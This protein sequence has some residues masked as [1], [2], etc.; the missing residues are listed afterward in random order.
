M[1]A[2]AKRF[3]QEEIVLLE[4]QQHCRKGDDMYLLYK[5]FPRAEENGYTPYCKFNSHLWM[6]Y[7]EAS[8]RSPAPSYRTS[9]QVSMVCDGMVSHKREV[10]D[11]S[12]SR[13][14]IVTCS[15]T[16]ST[17]NFSEAQCVRYGSLF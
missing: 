1:E 10:S 14:P 9:P 2:A 15:L 12:L 16:D 17:G 4:V 5:I 6:K 8:D 13:A 11:I 7:S 3:E